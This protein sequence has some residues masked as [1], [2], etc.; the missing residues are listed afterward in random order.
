MLA[1]GEQA[2]GPAPA[3]RAL[4]LPRE[5]DHERSRAS[6]LHR[7]TA[8]TAFLWTRRARGYSFYLLLICNLTLAPLRPSAPAVH[9]AIADAYAREAP[10]ALSLFGLPRCAELAVAPR[11]SAARVGADTGLLLGG[12]MTGNVG[13]R[14]PRICFVVGKGPGRLPGWFRGDECG[15]DCVRRWADR[16]DRDRSVAAHHRPD[17]RSAG[18]AVLL[19]LG[20]RVAQAA[21]AGGPLIGSE[22]GRI[23][24]VL[25][26]HDHYQ[27]NLDRAGRELLSQMGT[28]VTT[29]AGAR[30]L[31]GRAR[32]LRP[33]S[34]TVLDADGRPPIEITAT[35]CRHGPPGSSPV[36]GPVIGFS[37][38]WDGQAHGTLWISGD[39]VLFDGLRDVAR[40]MRVSIAVL[41]LGGVYVPVAIRPAALHAERR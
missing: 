29:Q 34:T 23:D 37:L 10:D 36:V 6:R 26:S 20:D 9:L 7:P 40:R 27:D 19:R 28:I 31:G 1:G 32:G 14:C 39:T 8:A 11:V 5:S 12:G 18:S 4:L 24:A 13:T 30:R 22:L 17:F 15:A 41:N 2:D 35:P 25:L 3:T 21:R 33:W 38:R 16:R